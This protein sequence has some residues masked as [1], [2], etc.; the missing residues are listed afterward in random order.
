MLEM[1]DMH[2][3]SGLEGQKFRAFASPTHM[4]AKVYRLSKS[5]PE[6]KEML[7]NW[8]QNAEDGDGSMTGTR[9]IRSAICLLVW[10]LNIM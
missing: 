1:F 3:A 9:E 6:S 10:A 8:L 2:A 7:A 5:R 4:S